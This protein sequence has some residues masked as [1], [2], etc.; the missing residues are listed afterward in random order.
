M[1]DASMSRGVGIHAVPWTPT[2]VASATE[3]LPEHCDVVVRA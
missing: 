3:R 2:F 1:T